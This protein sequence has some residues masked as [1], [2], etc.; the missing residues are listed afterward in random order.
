MTQIHSV[1]FGLHILGTWI[2][3]YPESKI[4]TRIDE[5]TANANWSQ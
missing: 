3:K 5:F 4:S 1:G 2:V